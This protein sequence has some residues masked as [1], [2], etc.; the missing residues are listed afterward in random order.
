MFTIVY[1]HKKGTN[2]LLIQYFLTII[3]VP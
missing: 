3:L 2:V 1:E